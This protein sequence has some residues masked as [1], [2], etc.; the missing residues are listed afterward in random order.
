MTLQNGPPGLDYE[1]DMKFSKV[2]ALELKPSGDVE[3]L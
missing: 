2:I 1:R 3:F